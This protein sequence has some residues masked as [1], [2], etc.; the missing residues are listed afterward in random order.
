MGLL[1]DKSTVESFNL[2]EIMLVGRA[3]SAVVRVLYSGRLRSDRGPRD[4]RHRHARG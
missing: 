2:L 1:D 3:V 4:L